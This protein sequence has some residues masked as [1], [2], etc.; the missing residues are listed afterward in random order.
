MKYTYIPLFL[1]CLI[2]PAIAQD[3][4]V[5]CES[6]TGSLEDT[7]YST[8]ERTVIHNGATQLMMFEYYR[9]VT[10]IEDCETPTATAAP[11]TSSEV[12]TFF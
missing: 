4:S 6:S 8:T 3:V 5:S 11:G 7:P 12:L 9:S 1:I 10:Y 2:A